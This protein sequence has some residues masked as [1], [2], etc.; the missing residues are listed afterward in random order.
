MITKKIIAATALAGVLLTGGIAFAQGNGMMLSVN[1][2]GSA[3]IHG[4]VTAVSGSTVTVSSWLGSWTVNASSVSLSDI[5]VG[6]QV[7]VA[8]TVTQNGGLT[9]T[10]KNIKENEKEKDQPKANAGE[11]VTIGLLTG[12]NTSAGTFSIQPKLLFLNTSGN[13]N[14]ATTSTT[15]V[16]LDGKESA[17]S[18]L[19]NSLGVIVAGS[20]NA[21]THV[22]TATTVRAFSKANLGLGGKTLSLGEKIKMGL[23]LGRK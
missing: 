5:A 11:R 3:K 14:V 1:G 22:L 19:S 9:I 8:G 13:V 20:W 16:F 18:S 23:G 4:T 2:D 17:L 15:K 12:L 21:D 6:D 10:A 7:T